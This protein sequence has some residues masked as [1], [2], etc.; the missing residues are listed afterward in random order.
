MT[1]SASLLAVLAVVGALVAFFVLRAPPAVAPSLAPAAPPPS[2]ATPPPPDAAAE[3]APEVTTL[4]DD[5]A[6]QLLVFPVRVE[7][8]RFRV[9]DLGMTARPRARAPGERRLVRGERRVLRLGAGSAP[10]GS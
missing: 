4:E 8:A 10:R 6:F 7:G 3:I 9:V 2:I 1:R 5:D